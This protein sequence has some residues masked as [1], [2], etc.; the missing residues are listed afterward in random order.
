LTYK[1]TTTERVRRDLLL[2]YAIV[3]PEAVDPEGEAEWLEV[4]TEVGG[5]SVLGDQI[6]IIF[7]DDGPPDVLVSEFGSGNLRL[8]ITGTISSDHYLY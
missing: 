5:W 4:S 3:D 7:T 2:E 8:R 6:G 1:G